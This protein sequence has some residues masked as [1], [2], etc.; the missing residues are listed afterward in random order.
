M[1]QQNLELPIR[2]TQSAERAGLDVQLPRRLPRLASDLAINGASPAFA[3]PLHVGRPSL[4]AQ[5]RFL[6]LTRQMLSSGWLTNN[7]PL[8]QQFES[9]LQA[10]LCVRHC[11]SVCNGTVAM[12][13]ALRALDLTGE[14]ILPSY[15]FIATASAVEWMN[16]T[17]VFADIDPASHNLSAR[18]VAQQITDRTSAIL[19][20]HLWGNAADISGLQQ[21]A[22]AR[23]LHVLYDT[24]HGFASTYGQRRL[25]GFGDCEVFSF[26]ATKFFHSIEGGAVTTNDDALADRLRKMRNFGFAGLDHVV[27][28]GINGKLS[29]VHAAMGLANLS[30]LDTLTAINRRNY[31]SYA[32]AISEIDGLTLLPLTEPQQNNHQYVVLEV[33][34][35]YRPGRDRLLDAL[36]AENVLARR[37]FWPG[38][39]RMPAYAGKADHQRGPLPHTEAVADRVIVLPTGPGVG[40]DAIELVARVCRL[41]A[42]EAR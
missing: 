29:E 21:V 13:L 10:Y 36:R 5:E 6:E 25:G 16:L 23:G 18:A 22:E 27:G 24:A 9:E 20:V 42:G 28:P 12:L 17:P 37:Y 32:Q 31:A 14:V 4:L 7:G 38:I 8:V 26:H 33:G 2:A 39:H 19:P 15:T 34:P 40:D 11:I 1:G 3:H 41:L 30:V 35:D